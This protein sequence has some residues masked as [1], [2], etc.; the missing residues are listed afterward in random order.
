MNI[1]AEIKMESDRKKARG[2]F[3]KKREKKTLKKR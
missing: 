3:R 2:F 1:A